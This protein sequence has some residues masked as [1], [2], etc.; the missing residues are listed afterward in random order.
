MYLRMLSV[1]YGH[2]YLCFEVSRKIQLLIIIG[3]PECLQKS[4]CFLFKQLLI[5]AHGKLFV[6][7]EGICSTLLK[8]LPEL[9]SSRKCYHHEF[10]K[11]FLFLE[12][13]HSE[14]NSSMKTRFRMHQN[15]ICSHSNSDVV[16][17]ICF[18]WPVSRNFWVPK[19]WSQ[20]TIV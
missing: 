20:Q 16:W 4:T 9:W 8:E 12:K 10:W 19:P 5:C 17:K 3:C 18:F 11:V 14:D 13:Y 6:S 1:Y 15:K 2:K 7:L